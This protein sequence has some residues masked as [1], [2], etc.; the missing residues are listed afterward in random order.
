MASLRKP[1]RL[2]LLG[3]DE[4]T[5]R[6]L[7][8]GGEDLRN[9]ERIEQLLTCMNGLL[10]PAE[11]QGGVSGR[12]GGHRVRTY[13]VVPMTTEVG[14]L[15]WVPGTVPL[16]ALITQGLQHDAHF[17]NKNNQ[18]LQALKRGGKGGGGGSGS[19]GGSIG[20]SPAELAA[21]A[22]G[23][24]VSFSDPDH[25]APAHVL[26]HQVLGGGV[27]AAQYHHMYKALPA[28]KLVPL[29]TGGMAG[30][31]PTDVLR[32]ALVT[33][34]SAGGG[35]EAF[36]SLR[37]ELGKSLGVSSAAGYVLGLGDRHLDNLLLDTTTG[38]LVPIDFGLAFG[39]GASVLPVP[40]MLPFR[41]TPQ[42]TEMLA[43][44]DA[45]GLLAA[46]ATVAMRA[47]RAEA[48]MLTRTMDIFL[49]DPIVDW[50][51]ACDKSRPK[52]DDDEDEEKEDESGGV[53]WEPARRIR[54]AARKLHGANPMDVLVDDLRQNPAVAKFGSL[55]SLEGIVRGQDPGQG[56]AHGGGGLVPE[57]L[58]VQRLQAESLGAADQVACLMDLATD[59]NILGRQ[60]IG[61]ATWV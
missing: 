33:M 42:L 57:R 25:H 41:L 24:A 29:F 12:R 13:S 54:N 17:L 52:G 23:G 47:F 9:D 55:R 39:M 2:G 60:W 20:L 56:R 48:A 19:G 14:L 30:V 36:L 6:F 61:L 11:G 7:V 15:E 21:A 22:Q 49:Q 3:S 58:S 59:P 43:P 10:C 53:V 18:D 26:V 28:S 46:H 32:R 51:S 34:A 45:K 1:K 37:G 4:K 40:E 35:P 16:K 44:L 38:Q 31:L 8:K 5:H 50:L 27:S